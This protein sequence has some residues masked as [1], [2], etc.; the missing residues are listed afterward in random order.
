MQHSLCII[1]CLLTKAKESQASVF[2]Y[3]IPLMVIFKFLW[4]PWH[5][6]KIAN[7][8]SAWYWLKVQTFLLKNHFQSNVV[9]LIALIVNF[10]THSA[11]FRLT[12]NVWRYQRGKQKPLFIERDVQWPSKKT[13]TDKQWLSNMKKLNQ[14]QDTQRRQTK[15]NNNGHSQDTQRKQTK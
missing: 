1:L 3:D 10:L 14:S 9:A 7:M 2:C 8:S 11:V 13:Q 4:W 12:R 6:F 15:T 5:L